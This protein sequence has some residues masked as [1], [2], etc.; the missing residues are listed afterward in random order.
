[1]TPFASW[2]SAYAA[3]ELQAYLH[4]PTG[5]ECL[6]RVGDVHQG[7]Q[8]ATPKQGTVRGYSV[9]DGYGGVGVAVAGGAEGAGGF[10]RDMRLTDVEMEQLTPQ[11][12]YTVMLTMVGM[13]V[14]VG[15]LLLAGLCWLVGGPQ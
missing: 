11:A 1:M 3:D 10:M 5:G 6:P 7:S 8:S 15:T 12:P 2:S 4:P 14:T 13:G 9:V